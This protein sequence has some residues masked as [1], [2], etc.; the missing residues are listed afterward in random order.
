MKELLILI[1][2]FFFYSCQ[3]E[4]NKAQENAI[5][6]SACK[7]CL[8]CSGVKLNEKVILTAAHCFANNENTQNIYIGSGSKRKTLLRKSI[9]KLSIHPEYV[10][11][12]AYFDIAV[13]ILENKISNSE[14]D[15]GFYQDE[16]DEE[17][18]LF[19]VSYEGI[20][21]TVKSHTLD[22]VGFGS[23]WVNDHKK[24]EICLGSS[25]GGIYIM[26]ESGP[27]L[28][29]IISGI[30][31]YPSELKGRSC[32]SGFRS[33]HSDLRFAKKWLL[34]QVVSTL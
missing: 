23:F 15:L 22:E 29:G 12:T 11:S 14:F 18:S 5:A 21:R 8:L 31:A 2:L 1:S 27:R 6:L 34:D 17:Q 13:V 9:H 33:R 3:E 30:D 16:L 24:N 7:N 32:S 20:K 26:E 10:R 25:G 19:S 28:L 4:I